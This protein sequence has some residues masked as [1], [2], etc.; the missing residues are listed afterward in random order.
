VDRV[1]KRTYRPDQKK[2]GNGSFWFAIKMIFFAFIL[3]RDI[4][5]GALTSA[6]YSTLNAG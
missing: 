3:I 4:V 2:N 6:A 5:D 1:E